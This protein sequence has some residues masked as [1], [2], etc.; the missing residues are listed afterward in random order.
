[1]HLIRAQQ[2]VTIC[3]AKNEWV[4]AQER[5]RR[6]VRESPLG[7]A[8]RIQHPNKLPFSPPPSKTGVTRQRRGPTSSELPRAWIDFK[9]LHSEFETPPLPRR[10]QRIDLTFTT[11]RHVNHPTALL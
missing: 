11:C 10:I 3:A 5:R 4:G 9:L 2:V 7:I 1:M 8:S 6:S